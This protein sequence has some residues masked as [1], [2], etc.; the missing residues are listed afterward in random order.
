MRAIVVSGGGVAAFC[1][2]QDIKE[3]AALDRPGRIAAHAAG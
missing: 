1:A 2:G 3:L